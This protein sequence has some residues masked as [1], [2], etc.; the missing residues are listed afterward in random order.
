MIK[1]SILILGVFF[2]IISISTTAKAVQNVTTEE[3][4]NTAIQNNENEIVLENDIY[5]ENTVIIPEGKSITLDLNGKQITVKKNGL[6][7]LYA[8]DNNGSFILKDSIGGGAITARGIENLETGN[9]QIDSGIIIACDTNGGAA[10]WNDGD[11]TINGGSFKTTYE[12]L[13]SDT[14]GPGCLNNGGKAIINGGIFSSVSRRTYAVISTGNIEL[15]NEP[16]VI[17]AHGGL[18]IDAGTA[19][20]NGGNFESTEYYGL[21]VSNDGTGMDPEQAQVTVNNGVF[22]GKTYSVWIGSD[23]NNPVNSTIQINGGTFNKSLSV[24][25][26]VEENAGI[27]VYGGKF[28]SDVTQYTMPGYICQMQDD[29]Y[30]VLKEYKINI[31]DT[32]N[33][34]V[35]TNLQKAIKGTTVKLTINANQGY[36]IDQITVSGKDG[37]INVNNNEFIMPNSDVTINVSFKKLTQEVKV[38]GENIIFAQDEEKVKEVLNKTLEQDSNLS[39]LAKTTNLD[40]IVQMPY[41]AF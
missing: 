36:E 3:E 39:E 27:K 8:I 34:A 29:Y 25:S 7:S 37:S 21:Y 18:A 5:L 30:Y 20:V 2:L 19:T 9:M 14:Y 41:R 1:K 15:N 33:G 11:L 23:V 13:P 26:N 32:E 22:T 35:S 38:I 40:I 17:G 24:Q 16:Q 12:G 10:I 6:R 28:I 31:E 4:I